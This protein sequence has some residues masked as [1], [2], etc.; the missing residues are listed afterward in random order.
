MGNDPVE[1]AFMSIKGRE[2]W[3]IPWL[4]EDPKLTQPQFWVGRMRK[5]A[6]EAL[7]Y[8]CNGLL[9]IHW[10]TRVFGPNVAALADAA[11]NQKQLY[12]TGDKN[13]NDV[14]VLGG[15]TEVNGAV[16]LNKTA[17]SYL[18]RSFRGGLDGYNFKLPNG[19]YKLT[20]KFAECY[21]DQADKRVF[22]IS[23]QG[24]KVFENFDIAARVGRNNG[25]DV[26]TTCEV[27]DGKLTLRFV[28]VKDIPNIS[29]IVIEGE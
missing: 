3:A 18:Y 8:G 25:L 6:F 15:N 17:D 13:N 19:N 1:P 21:Y 23:I 28:S 16:I 2:K 10:R 4:E 11:W 20:L 26:E 7:S 24:K 27:T 12:S 9:G 29:A 14:E 5:D 22:D